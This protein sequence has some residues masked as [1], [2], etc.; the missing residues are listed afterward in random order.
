MKRIQ[1]GNTVFEGENDAY[2]IEADRTTLVDT[3][4]SIPAVR[5]DLRE[6]LSGHG[7]DFADVDAIVLTHWHPDHAGLAGEIQA[8]GGASVYVHEADAPL[9]DGRERPLAADP[10]VRREMFDRWGM[11][12]EARER[13]TDFFERAGTDIYGREADVTPIGDGETI[14]LGGV[15]LETVHLPGHTAGLC[16][17]AFDPRTVPGHAPVRGSG[18]GGTAGA[19][20]RDDRPPAEAFT[21]DALLPRYTPNVGGAD[22]R[23]ETPLAAYADSLVRI[24]ERDWDAAHPGHRER[25]DEPSRRAAE[26]LDHHR[27]RTRR[28][29]GVLESGPATAW[30]VSAALFGD[31]EGIHTLHGP[32]EAFAHLDHLERAGVL[33]RDGTAYRLVDPDPS[34]D[35]LFPSVALDATGR[36]L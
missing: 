15:T 8:E 34:V 1:L 24:V 33:E 4:V 32:G 17:F 21:G 5:A 16:A 20:A 27:D 3:A 25:I 11:P 14:D 22:V 26:I 7:V 10:A 12:A 18:E 28:V 30:E 35:A 36:D 23:V 31:L 6:G 29:I 9:V 2:L 13:L 19:S